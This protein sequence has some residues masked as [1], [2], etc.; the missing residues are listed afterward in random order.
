MRCLVQRRRNV[1]HRRNLQSKHHRQ[2]RFGLSEEVYY[3]VRVAKV[4]SSYCC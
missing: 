4:H 3:R 2:F 1:P